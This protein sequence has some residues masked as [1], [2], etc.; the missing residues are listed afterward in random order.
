M[1]AQPSHDPG[2]LLADHLHLGQTGVKTDEEVGAVA[3]P[4]LARPRFTS[5]MRV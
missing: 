5:H 4:S 2:V 3:A 1:R